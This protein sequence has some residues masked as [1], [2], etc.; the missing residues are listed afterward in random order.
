MV[1]ETGP[2]VSPSSPT[3]LWRQVM[4]TIRAGIES[5]RWSENERILSERE[6]SAVLGVS[7]NTVRQAINEAVSAGLLTRV[8]GRGTFV[9]PRHVNQPLAW[10]QGFEETLRA[11]GILPGSRLTSVGVQRVG[12]PASIQLVGEEACDVMF[13]RIVGLGDGSP[14]VVYDSYVPLDLGAPLQA[15]LGRLVRESHLLLV[16]RILAARFGW[17]HLQAYQT[18]EACAASADIAGLLEV[19]AATP[20]LKVT[21]LFSNPSGR[22]VEYHEAFYRS[23]KYRFHITR[24]LVFSEAQ[25]PMPGDVRGYGDRAGEEGDAGGKAGHRYQPFIHGRP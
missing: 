13:V 24:Q 18:Y 23:D 22:P 9:A 4:E 21:T 25:H 17:A 8:Q 10:M 14:M 12:P 15:D 16:N 3:P 6:L 20:V 11:R 5:G 1:L 19:A 7:R 2:G